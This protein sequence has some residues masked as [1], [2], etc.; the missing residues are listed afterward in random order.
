MNILN[1]WQTAK[2]VNGDEINVKLVPLKRQ[3]NTN[4]GLIWVDVGQMIELETG[5]TFNLNLDGKSFY[6]GPNQL[7]RLA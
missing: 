7:Y 5:E 3:Q 2:A 4:A 1:T 6:T